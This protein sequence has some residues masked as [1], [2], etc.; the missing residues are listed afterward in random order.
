M[1]DKFYSFKGLHDTFRIVII[2]YNSRC[3]LKQKRNIHKLLGLD[4]GDIQFYKKNEYATL[5][6]PYY[7]LSHHHNCWTLKYKNQANADSLIFNTYLLHKW[8]CMEN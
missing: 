4:E 1:I 5:Q 6:R 3:S 8:A 7:N 2:I